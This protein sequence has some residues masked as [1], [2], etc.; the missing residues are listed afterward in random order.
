LDIVIS[1][2]I[3]IW[4]PVYIYYPAFLVIQES[5]KVITVSWILKIYAVVLIAIIPDRQTIFSVN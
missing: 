1:R 2:N 5:A 3:T 4:Y